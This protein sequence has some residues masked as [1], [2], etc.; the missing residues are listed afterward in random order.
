[1]ANDGGDAAI[2]Y[3]VEWAL[4]GHGVLAHPEGMVHW[5]ADRIHPLFAGVAEMAV[6]A[7]REA[8]TRGVDRPVYIVPIV[9]KLHYTRDVTGALH[10]EMDR[11]ERA[12]GLDSI[13]SKAVAAR[14]AAVQERILARQMRHFG[15]DAGSVAGRDFFQRQDA[16]RAHLIAD[17]Q[18]R[19]R[20]A[21]GDSVERTI[22]RLAK[23]IHS[24][25]AELAGDPLLHEDTARVREAERLGGF[26]R[27]AYATPMLSQEQIGESLKRI[28]ATLMRHGRRNVLHNFLPKPHG[29]RTVHVRV[30]EPLLIDRHRAMD[31]ERC[32]AYVRE[33]MDETRSRMQAALDAITADVWG[34]SHPNPFADRPETTPR[35]RAAYDGDSGSGTSRS[36][37]GFSTR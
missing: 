8:T 19:Y 10:R 14:F 6:R 32:G 26:S 2:E 1:V 28:R 34:F 22:H 16:F 13:A 3:S 7:I 4:R 36:L 30:P 27:D 21:L 33:L 23:A 5:T 20:V 9:W 17:L 12:L 29:P 25:R 11:I 37:S 18:S 35:V 15:F 24:R 31:P